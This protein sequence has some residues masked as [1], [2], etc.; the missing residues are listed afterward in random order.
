MYETQP[1]KAID[2]SGQ[3]LEDF[4]REIARDHGADVQ[5][6][7]ANGASQVVGVL[8]GAGLVTAHHQKLVDASSTMRNATAHRKDKKTLKPW[9]ATPAGAFAAIAV[10]LTA[11]RSIYHFVKNGRQ[12]I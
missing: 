1:R 5:A 8:A 7:K 12:T 6:K 3:A 10:T 9:E 4:L 2:A 11:I